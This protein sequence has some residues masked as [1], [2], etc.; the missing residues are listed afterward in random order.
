MDKYLI[1]LLD[2]ATVHDDDVAVLESDGQ[3]SRLLL[4]V[5]DLWVFLKRGY[6]SFV[7]GAEFHDCICAEGE[8]GD[9]WS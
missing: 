8:G 1:E 4:L 5:F 6:V 9:G 2:R 7:L 3:D